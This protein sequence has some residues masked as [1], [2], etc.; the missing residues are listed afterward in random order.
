MGISKQVLDRLPTS[1]G[2]Y[3][4]LDE[5]GKVI[6]IGKAKSIRA[7]VRSYFRGSDDGRLFFPF[8]VRKTHGLDFF[9]TDNEKEALLLENN[10]IK[11]DHPRYNIN[12]RDDKTYLSLKVTKDESFPRV[13]VVRRVKKDGGKYFGPYA[14]ASA[15]RSTLKMVRKTFPLRTCSNANFRNR[16]RPCLQ[17]QIHRCGAPCVGLQSE[18]E[19]DRIV[20]EM[21]LFLRGRNTAVLD[22]LRKRMEL[23]ASGLH[24]EAAA[25]I[26]DQIR[27]LNK[28]IERQRV[29]RADLMDRDVFGFARDGDL[30]LFQA[31]FIREGKINASRNFRFRSQLPTNEIMNSLL[32]QYYTPER[33]V[34]KEILCPVA[35]Q[36]RSMLEE[37]LTERRGNR[38]RILIPQRGEKRSLVELATKNAQVVVEQ[39]EAKDQAADELLRSLRERLGLR[40]IPQRIEC[41]DIS[42]IQGAYTVG[43]MVSFQRAEPHKSGYRKFRIRTVEGPDDFASLR[44]VITRRYKRA[45]EQGELPDLVVIDGGKGQLSSSLAALTELG[46]EEMDIVALAKARTRGG[47]T[48]PERVYKPGR[49]MPIV[50]PQDSGEVYLLARIRDE[51]HRFAISYHR[52][53]RRKETLRAK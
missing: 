20:D 18:E 29:S 22:R 36:D 52:T 32:G 16:S 33:E 4:F 39:G 11:K 27:D 35:P 5:R 40:S 9:V 25:R 19:Y 42:H 8:I 23:E 17:Y 3:R 31:V 24:F 1:P 53:L 30:T 50:L 10:L 15:V 45:I 13:V 47:R 21:I 28:T 46:L 34:P 43:G 2:V 37:I 38:V 7:R 41:F 26:R 49:A 14:S 12:L 6:Y 51:A 44:E 48:T